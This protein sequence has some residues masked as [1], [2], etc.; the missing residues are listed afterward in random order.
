VIENIESNR[1]FFKN[2]FGRLQ[3]RQSKG[4]SRQWNSRP[5]G[6]AP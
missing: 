3:L 5:K 6:G 2:L 1:V 4:T